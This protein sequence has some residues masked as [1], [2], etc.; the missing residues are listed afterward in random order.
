MIGHL[1]VAYSCYRQHAEPLVVWIT[2]TT[3]CMMVALPGLADGSNETLRSDKIVLGRVAYED[4]I[5]QTALDALGEYLVEMSDDLIQHETR[6]VKSNHEMIELLR[7]GKVDL[8]PETPFPALMYEGAASAKILVR[9]WQDGHSGY[10]THFFTRHSSDVQRIDDLAGKTVVFKS[11]SSTAGCLVP[12]AA[13]TD[14]SLVVGFPGEALDGSRVGLIFSNSEM[15]TLG[16][17]AR[18]RAD[19]GVMSSVD[20]ADDSVA[21]RGLKKHLRIFHTTP[22]IIRA[23]MLARPGLPKMRMQNIVDIL[24]RMHESDKGKAVLRRFYSTT[25]F[26][27]LAGDALAS[28]DDVRLLAHELGMLPH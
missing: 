2:V 3:F 10:R 17:V 18:G 19:A 7:A 14:R 22:D 12:K 11:P 26:D 20:W 23:V 1:Q 8:V 4:R 21:P 9:Q 15:N 13:I 28:L 25:R 16:W 24:L 6:L 5:D 27:S